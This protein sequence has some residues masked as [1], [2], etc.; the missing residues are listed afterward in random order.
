MAGLTSNDLG[1][2]PV[3][4]FVLVGRNGVGKSPTVE[5]EKAAHSQTSG[6]VTL[7]GTGP[8]W[9]WVSSRAR[10]GLVLPEPHRANERTPSGS[11]PF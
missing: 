4:I 11:L 7:L 1:V 10:I 6:H 9:A 8:S 3:E 5:I 2:Y